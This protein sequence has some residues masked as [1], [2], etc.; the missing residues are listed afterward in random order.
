[1]SCLLTLRLAEQSRLSMEEIAL[2]PYL[3]KMDRLGQVKIHYRSSHSPQWTSAVVY[4]KNN[5]QKEV[6]A[7]NSTAIV[8]FPHRNSS[9]FKQAGKHM[10]SFHREKHAL[11]GAQVGR[12]PG[13]KLKTLRHRQNKCR[14]M[15]PRVTEK[16]KKDKE[17]AGHR[18]DLRSAPTIFFI[19]SKCF[20]Q[21]QEDNW[22]TP[23]PTT[24]P[25]ARG[26]SHSLFV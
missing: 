24:S 11:S 22:V 26:R 1:M 6:P 19:F 14:Q 18:S 10:H 4:K 12:Q 25:I 9:W 21:K 8:L 16:K 17:V 20:Q 3:K 7:C 13:M 2:S 23:A 5:F 15:Q